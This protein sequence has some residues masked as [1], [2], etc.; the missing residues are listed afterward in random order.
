MS[1]IIININEA[2]KAQ[3]YQDEKE[4]FQIEAFKNVAKILQEHKVDEKKSLEITDCRFHD[5]IFI[6]GDRGVGKTAF[7]INIENY[8]NQYFQVAKKPKYIFLKSVDP[9]LLE[10]TEKFLSVVLARI[11]EY[12]SKENVNDEN[13]YKALEKLS[14]SLEAIKTLDKDV[15][16]EEIASNKS[17]LKLEQHAHEFFQIVSKMFDVDAI[18]MLID[19]VD[20]AFDKGFDVLEV[21]RKYLASPY[22][23]PIVAGDMKLYREIVETRFKEKIQFFQDM[24]Y[25]KDLSANL[26]DSEEYKEKMKLLNNLV[27]QYLHKVFPSE[28]H[29]K[30]KDIFSILKSN[31]VKI[32]INGKDIDY[33]DLK[34]FEIRVINWGINQKEFTHQVFTNNTRDF[35]QYLYH[36]K[37]I[38]EKIFDEKY[39]AQTYKEKEISKPYSIITSRFDAL[40][41]E[42]IISKSD[43][44]QKTLKL[45]ADFYRY[46]NDVDKK[47]LS[48]LLDNDVESFNKKGY[49]IHK[50]LRGSFFLNEKAPYNKIDSEVVR[51][52]LYLPKKQFLKELENKTSSEYLSLYLMLHDNYYSN[53]TNKILMITG[54]FVEAII[55]IIDETL[56]VEE[57][58]EKINA[59][60]Y[61]IPILAGIGRNRYIDKLGKDE[62]E[63]EK[64]KNKTLL[65]LP[66]NDYSK[67]INSFKERIDLKFT[68]VF[69]YE[70]LKKY[71]NN[72]NILK[73]GDYSKAYE[74]VGAEVNPIIMTSKLYDYVQ[75]VGYIF[76]NS[77][78]SFESKEN[79]STENIAVDGKIENIKT[80]SKVF[81]NNIQKLEEGTLTNFLHQKLNEIVFKEQLDDILKKIILEK[82]KIVVKKDNNK[83]LT[84]RQLDNRYSNCYSK[85]FIN[86]N[87]REELIFKDVCKPYLEEVINIFE[88][89]GKNNY[90]ESK[91]LLSNIN[92]KY[93]KVYF[94]LADDAKNENNI[95]DEQQL[96]D[97][98]NQLI[99]G[100]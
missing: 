75:R 92:K 82:S 93:S 69:L 98:Y 87:Y 21:V 42:R 34:D 64:D 20:M 99:Y 78:A 16:I 84:H 76:L 59:L 61:G 33:R 54:K 65:T 19:D 3:K 5:T 53:A 4:L 47:R 1:E 36:K 91:A 94:V 27:E 90:K 18:V 25:L 41:K 44:H 17:S 71:I 46:A 39:D 67:F 77:I 31:E 12:V 60:N 56:T 89:L 72:L 35:V 22:L 79:T 86:N 29:I 74:A 10:H 2:N 52:K 48:L 68:S 13:Y 57:K 73:A 70:M 14:K 50:A 81:I 55:C 8:Y 32:K 88:S 37:E 62:D 38:F 40:I 49:S 83:P 23:I 43:E 58:K 28:Y 100:E 9:T 26:K 7:M 30:L 63:E 45:T 11:V 80:H 66:N 6:D 51:D 24:K 96:F 95:P 15:G 97:K 85:Y